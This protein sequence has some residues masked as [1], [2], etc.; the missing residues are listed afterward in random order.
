MLFRLTTFSACDGLCML[1]QADQVINTDLI[2]EILGYPGGEELPEFWAT[3][4]ANRT[5]HAVTLAAG[6]PEYTEVQTLFKT[7]CT[8]NIIKVDTFNTCCMP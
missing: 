2:C 3:M 5:S 6:T 4:P 7:T 1:L 8:Q